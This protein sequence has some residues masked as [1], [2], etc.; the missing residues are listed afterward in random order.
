MIDKLMNSKK[1]AALIVTFNPELNQLS[2][3]IDLI[4]SQVDYVIIVDNTPESY[5][6]FNNP[7]I[8]LKKMECNL[9][10]AR[11]QNE[12]I[13][14]AIK[15]GVHFLFTFDQDSLIEDDF[16]AKM[17][18]AYEELSVKETISCL[19]PNINNDFLTNGY[20]KKDFII[21]SGALFNIDVFKEVG[22]F[23]SSWFIDMIDV[24]W[25][26]R[27]RRLSLFSF[28]ANSVAMKHNVGE[29]DYP[30]FLGRTIHIGSP[31]RQYYLVRNWILSLKSPSFPFSYKL[32]VITLLLKK[33]PMFI[34]IPPKK[35]RFGFVIKGIIDGVR[36][37]LGA[38]H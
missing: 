18:T 5:V 3:F 27:A 21:S 4:E 28:I 23:E 22:L 17:I 13:F 1:S 12:G 10:I 24:E 34:L 14:L 31:V 7:K 8:I 9:G 30:V 35:K 15:F 32:Y 36:N 19:G 6:N 25:C 11:A 16:C 2:K 20:T 29:N 26:Y 33:V 37:K 38:Y